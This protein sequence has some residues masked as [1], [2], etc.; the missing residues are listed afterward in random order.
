MPDTDYRLADAAVEIEE[1]ID[2]WDS[3]SPEE[4]H[5]ALKRLQEVLLEGID[6]W[7]IREEASERIAGVRGMH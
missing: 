2:C 3:F 4:H 1:Q 5:E 7:D 6:D